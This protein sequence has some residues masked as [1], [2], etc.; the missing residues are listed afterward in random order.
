MLKEK[1]NK[2]VCLLM[3]HICVNFQP[4]SLKN[5]GQTQCYPG[6]KQTKKQKFKTVLDYRRYL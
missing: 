1:K 5:F 2:P 6:Q 3:T 4:S